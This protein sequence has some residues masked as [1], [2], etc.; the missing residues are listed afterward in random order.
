MLVLAHHISQNCLKI[1]LDNK[2]VYD[3]FKVLLLYRAGL[4]DV[5]GLDWLRMF[6]SRE[7]STLISGAEHEISVTDLQ[8]HTNYSG[9]YDINHP[10]IT[11]FWQ[12]VTGMEEDQK[13]SLLKF[14][15]SCSRP[16][17]LGFKV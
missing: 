14:V 8:Q 5:I 15:T 13:R 17:L 11:A 6:S 9:G 7:L 16:P 4:S 1:A 3:V 2:N 10:T 12:V